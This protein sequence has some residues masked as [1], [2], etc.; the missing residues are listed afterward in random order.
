MSN[1]NILRWVAPG[2]MVLLLAIL[3]RRRLYK[4]F[5]VFFW[6]C[7]SIIC[8]TV[9]RYLAYGQPTRY[10]LVYWFTE[11]CYLVIAFISILSVLRPLTELEYSRH[12]WSRFVLLPFLVVTTSAVCWMAIFKPINRTTAGRVASALYVFVIVMCLAELLLFMI[13]F[14]VR[15]RAIVWTPYEF[16]ILKGFGALAAL[17][18]VA[19]LALI[20]RLFHFTVSP[21]FEQIF[22]AFPVGAFLASAAVWLLSFWKPEPPRS[23]PPDIGGFLDALNLASEQYRAQAEFLRRL[24]RQLGLRFAE[25]R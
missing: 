19:Y 9:L 1:T 14:N 4:R 18:L 23:D 25:S 12:P 22:Q 10:F 11:A 16:G 13:S 7:L 24:S 17:N 21:Q 3:V 8:I 20:L 15:R 5:P 2:L 6:Y